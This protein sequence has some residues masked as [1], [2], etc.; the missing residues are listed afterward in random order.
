MR[1]LVID[2]FAGG[3]GASMGIKLAIGRDVDYAINHDP[4]AINMHMTNHPNTIHFC[5]DVWEIDPRKVADGR[6][7][8]LCWFSPDCKHF[9]K[10]KGAKPVDK[11]V[12]G[13]AWVAVRWAATVKPRVLILENV[14]E[15][16]TWGPLINGRPDLKQQGR[17]FNCFVNALKRQ[18]YQ[19]E[20]RELVAS[21]YGAPTIRKRFFL[22]ARC[23]E[24][25]IRWPQATHG[26]PESPAV[27]SGILKPWHSAAEIIDWSIPMQSIFTR[28]KPLVEASNRRL[29]RGM[30]RY[31]INNPNPYVLPV[32]ED[33]AYAAFIGR[34]FGTAIGHSITEPMR[35]VMPG[36]AGGKSQLVTAFLTKYHGEKSNTE[37][38][39]QSLDEPLKTVDTSNR[40]GL[41]AGSLSKVEPSEILVDANQRGKVWAFL[42]KYYGTST[43]QSLHEPLATITTRDRFALVVVH[44]ELYCIDDIFMRML[45]PPELFAAQGF[46]GDYIIHRDWAGRPVLKKDQIA[47][48]GNAVPPAFAEA[49][50]R[51][52]LP[53]LVETKL[54]VA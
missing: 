48:C 37:V 30:Y 42:L 52:N 9:S 26:N 34:Q 53:D 16:V 1:E 39:G 15:F 11:K 50:V 14:E 36:G 45:Q 4:A 20:W 24:L 17:E 13:L 12:R 47:R 8:A 6:P 51:V 7:I 33:S 40:F 10:S 46:P 49:L 21:D 32:T 18:G 19:V 27:K 2:N 41:V 54:Q 29:A 22:I 44:G 35:T 38:R 28:K 25:P 3:G 31:I 5:E 43:G 23:D